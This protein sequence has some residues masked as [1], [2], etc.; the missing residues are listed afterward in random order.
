MVHVEA[1]GELRAEAREELDRQAAHLLLAPAL[2]GL[3]GDVMF[4][5]LERG[6]GERSCLSQ[7]VEGAKHRCVVE[8]GPAGREG[9]GGLKALPV[10][11]GE[12]VDDATVAPAGPA[13]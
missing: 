9:R 5:R 10:D 6:K 11:K 8:H 13:E 4:E 7:M 2:G 12:R 3:A 1:W